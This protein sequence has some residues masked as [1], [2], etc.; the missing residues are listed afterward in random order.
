MAI[1]E[2]RRETGGQEEVSTGWLPCA[3]CTLGP[4]GRGRQ[5][6]TAEGRFLLTQMRGDQK[7]LC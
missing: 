6:A 7:A 4:V 3:P 2:S 1:E 5:A